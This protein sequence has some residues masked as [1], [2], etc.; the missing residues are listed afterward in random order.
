M[1]PV[2]YAH[3]APVA[4]SASIALLCMRRYVLGA[5][6]LVLL[7]FF[8]RPG[9][10]R[11]FGDSPNVVYSPC[12]GKVVSIERDTQ[13]T[14]IAVFLNIHNVHVQYF[15]V[16]GKIVSVIHKPGSFHPA[17]MLQ[18]SEFN[19]RME[20]TLETAHG[21]VTIVQIS[22][23]IARRIVGFRKPGDKVAKGEPLG[24]IKLGSRVDIIVPSTATPMVR[25]GESI[26]IGDPVFVY[27]NKK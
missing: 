26:D 15:P 16:D 25:V 21:A 10:A 18:K 4:L 2:T 12:N 1:P 5:T 27:G 6:L 8:Y 20:T 19:E 3:N 7:L 13:K 24:L 23:Q 17:Y 9:N 14:R 22:G 11:N